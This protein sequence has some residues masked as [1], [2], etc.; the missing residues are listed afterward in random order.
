MR[1]GEAEVA[2]EVYRMTLRG[3][4]F[5]GSVVCGQREW[6]AMSASNPHLYLLVRERIGTEQE[7]ERLARGTA[8][9]SYRKGSGK[10]APPLRVPGSLPG[11]STTPDP[12]G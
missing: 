12:A 10:K 2:W 8:G 4:P 1:R 11:P 7:A 5:G 6:D 3:E 9:D